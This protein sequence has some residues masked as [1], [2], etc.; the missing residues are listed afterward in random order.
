MNAT[1]VLLEKRFK[2]SPVFVPGKTSQSTLATMQAEVVNLGFAFAPEVLEA[3][4]KVDER[5]TVMHFKEVLAVLKEMVGAHRRFKPMYPNFPQQVIE[6]GDAE[7]YFNAILHYFSSWIVDLSGDPEYIWLPKYDKADRRPLDEQDKTRV[8]VIKLG[9]E[10]DVFGVLAELLASNLAWSESDKKLVSEFVADE[11]CYGIM[12][13]SMPN[14]ENMAYL[15]GAVLKSRSL[16]PAREAVLAKLMKTAPDVLRVAVSLNDGDVSLAKPCRFRKLDRRER[17]LLLTALD[18][19]PNL[20]DDLRRH[21]EM[22]KRLAKWLHVQE[23]AS[24]FPNACKALHSVCDGEK[25]QGFRAKVHESLLLDDSSGAAD[26]LTIQPGEFARRLDHVLRTGN[27]HGYVLERFASVADRVSTPVMIQ[28]YANFDDRN[29][30]SPFRAAFPKG[31]VAKTKIIEKTRAPIPNEVCRDAMRIIR[32]SLVRRFAAKPSL[33]KCWVDERLKTQNVPFALRS[34]S[35]ALRTIARGSRIKMDD[36]DTIRFFIWWHDIVKTDSD[37]GR[38]VDVDL[39]ACSFGEDFSPL[40]TVSYFSLRDYSNRSGEVLACHSGDVTSAP[41]GACEFIDLNIPMAMQSRYRYVAM[42]VNS[43]SGQPFN[44]MPECFAGWMMR[45][46]PRSGEVFEPKT[47]QNKIDL[48]GETSFSVPIV[49]DLAN[50]EVIWTDLSMKSRAGFNVS[51]KKDK[52]VRVVETMAK[53]HRP[54]LYDLFR[55]HAEARGTLVETAEEADTV[56]SLHQGV[57]PYD[58]DVITS[59]YLA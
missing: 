11:K 34:A 26:L 37:H 27:R 50:R 44:E 52:I 33:G 56:F 24:R 49:L 35:K 14:R 31:S 51:T 12:P 21:E 13:E 36:G 48:T 4:G 8:R 41:K 54:N 53:L 40:G 25:H 28:A 15:I 6:A 19:A 46:K 39:S 32:D 23:W 47:V 10:A 43:F 42:T 20:M 22:W 1:K 59:E 45:Q 57:T 2:V 7:L 29:G 30:K 55:M 9:S 38:R 16:D 5:M 17:R 58:G 18:A 3:Y